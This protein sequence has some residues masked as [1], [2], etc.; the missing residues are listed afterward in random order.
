MTVQVSEGNGKK[1]ESG[2]AKWEKI[3]D[4]FFRDLLSLLFLG[5]TNR[6]WLSLS[7][8]VG[9]RLLRGLCILGFSFSFFFSSFSHSLLLFLTFFL[10]CASLSLSLATEISVAR[11]DFFFSH[12]SLFRKLFPSFSFNFKG[13]VLPSATDSLTVPGGFSQDPGENSALSWLISLLYAGAGDNQRRWAVYRNR[14]AERSRILFYVWRFRRSLFESQV[15]PSAPAVASSLV[16]LLREAGPWA[17]CVLPPDR[18]RVT[19][20]GAAA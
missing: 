9:N 15:V 11:R 3:G 14:R 6:R 19:S 10:A 20:W 12:L 1:K 5:R 18:S 2:T 4:E 13:L 16:C 7:L 8:S 17:G